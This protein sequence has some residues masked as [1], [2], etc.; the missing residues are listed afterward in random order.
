MSFKNTF[1]WSHSRQGNFEKCRR[2]YYL[3][4]YAMWGGWQSNATSIQRLC[5]CL[6][7]MTNQYMLVGS[8][9]HDSIEW[10]LKL[11]RMGHSTTLDDLRE[12][13]TNSVRRAW[14]ESTKQHWLHDP[15][16]TC[17]LFEHYYDRPIDTERMQ[18]TIMDSLYSF[19]THAL[20]TIIEHKD[21][22]KALEEFQSLNVGDYNITLK[23]DFAYEADGQ[24]HIIDWKTG[25]PDSRV[26]QQLMVYALYAAWKWGY[27]AEDIQTTAYYLLHEVR[28]LTPTEES[29][30]ER[31]KQI[32][33]QV[34]WMAAHL[35]DR[36]IERN[37]PL[38]PKMFPRTED[39]WKCG[40]CSY[41]EVCHGR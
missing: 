11:A 26:N 5:Y 3:R 37:K 30:H 10:Y 4:H 36:D 33:E 38:P 34:E 27:A 9:V 23:M 28:T 40:T 35:V 16:Y 29:L 20:P 18:A 21:N 31:L 41:R 19:Y 22:W 12:A 7:K 2:L 25:K 14:R 15:K 1:Q 32:V 8:I 39:Q 24:L 6:S 13:A 17:N